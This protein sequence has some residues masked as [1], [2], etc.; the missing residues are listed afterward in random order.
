MVAPSPP[1]N[2]LPQATVVAKRQLE[3]WQGVD[4]V[5]S[6]GAV[7]HAQGHGAEQQLELQHDGGFRQLLWTL[8]PRALSQRLPK[9]GRAGGV[10]AATNTQP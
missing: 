5:R 3:A 9:G 2:A 8:R 6:Q 7:G 1:L 10:V 4:A